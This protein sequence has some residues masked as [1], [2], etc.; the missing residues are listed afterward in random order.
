MKNLD[1][2]TGF[3]CLC[4]LIQF[5][6]SNH[7]KDQHIDIT[8]ASGVALE[9][10][11][12]SQ[13]NI[14]GIKFPLN[15]FAEGDKLTLQFRT[16]ST[17]GIIFHAQSHHYRHM[18]T[19]YIEDSQI[20]LRVV[21]QCRWMYVRDIAHDSIN[22]SDNNFH[23]LVILVRPTRVSFS[24]DHRDEQTFLYTTRSTFR[25]WHVEQF[26][27]GKPPNATAES[28]YQPPEFDHRIDGCIRYVTTTGTNNTDTDI[29]AS[30]KRVSSC[31]DLS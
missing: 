21:G 17:A 15:S 3:L 25:C 2:T 23:T 18:L 31:L 22:V 28:S 10:D 13:V 11:A 19:A 24:I 9:G 1:I 29:S 4:S 30:Y 12:Q 8:Q 27:F 20:R 7:L 26:F 6:V 16:T 14:T 5:T